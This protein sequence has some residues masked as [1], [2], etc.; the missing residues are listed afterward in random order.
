[1]GNLESKT[2]HPIE[3][4]NQFV[5]FSN[6]QIAFAHKSDK[7]LHKAAWLFRL[8]NSRWLV[9]LASSLAIM[10]VRWY[11]PLAK[12]L[13]KITIFEQFVGGET[14]YDCQDKISELWQN[15][16]LTVLDYGAEGRSDED[17]LDQARD[18][19]LKAVEFA[20]AH[21]SVPVV[22]IKVSALSKNS[23]LESIQSEMELSHQQID[24]RTRMV[25]RVDSICQTGHHYGVKIF[26]D[27]EETWIQD[28]ID[29]LVEQMMEKYNREKVIVYH[30]FQMYRKDRIDYLNRCHQEAQDKGYL[31]GAKIVRGAYLEK[32]RDRAEELVY[33]SPMHET[34]ADTD[35]DFDAA[36][37]FCLD[38]YKQIA[39]CAATHNSQS[40]LYQAELIGSRG[41]PKNHHHLNF[42]QLYGMSDHITFNLADAGFNVAKYVVYGEVKE[43]V[44]YLTR[45]AAENTAVKGEFSR[46]YALIKRELERRRV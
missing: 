31:L 8:M 35:K 33:T 2:T 14:L 20:A 5:D 41:L 44:P 16:T 43:V 22:S 32:E 38:H 7:A 42:C 40:C 3:E 15:R 45:R 13:I 4:K 6:T 28:T 1:M 26:I 27:A 37:R 10:A 34:K 21:E 11:L 9:T 23:L 29:K 46:E 17:D 18:H 30:T 39:S 25:E 12:W 24:W 36:L 19:F